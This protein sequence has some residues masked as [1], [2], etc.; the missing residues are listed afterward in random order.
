ME[1][2]G[3]MTP[4]A[5][6]HHIDSLP[7]LPAVVMKIKKV[8]AETNSSAKD[9]EDVLKMDPAIAGRIL[10][11]ANS[12]YIGLPHSVSS[13]KNAIVLLGRQR[14]HSLIMGSSIR[15]LFK[16]EPCHCFSSVN[17]WKHSVTVAIVAESIAEQ[18]RKR[19]PIDVGEIFSGGLLHDIGKLVLS[20]FDPAPL[21][22]AYQAAIETNTP[23]YQNEQR[24][25]NHTK[26]G[27][28]VAEKW[29]FPVSLVQTIKHH[30]SPEQEKNFK[31]NTT[32][33][34]VANI[35]A[36]ILGVNT[37][38]QETTPP[39]DETIVSRLLLEPEALRSISH[40]AI[41]REKCVE[42]F[43]DFFS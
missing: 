38:P 34:Y 25:H 42:S 30:H 33:V 26:I 7:S 20:V 17:F 27:V 24:E 12:A 11:L 10:R 29:N 31:R 13:L 6:A 41:Q 21:I 14:I 5:L 35:M 8:L 1:E 22:I 18:I 4:E 40:S 39:L 23:F 32:I 9:I 15:S 2:T 16:T 37:V 28:L 36:H 3:S 43:I 19:T